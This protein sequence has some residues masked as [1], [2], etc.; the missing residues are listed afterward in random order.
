MMDYELDQTR[1]WQNKQWD[2]FPPL[3]RE[4][5]GGLMA[6]GGPWHNELCGLVDRFQAV[7]NAPSI[8][9]KVAAGV[10]FGLVGGRGGGKTQIAACLGRYTIG[11]GHTAKY[12]TAQ[13]LFRRLRESFNNRNLTEQQVID[14]MVTPSV[15]ILDELHDRA[16]TKHEERTLNAVINDR[17]TR[18]R[19]TL[20]ISD[21]TAERFAESIGPSIASRFEEAG[22]IV[23]VTWPS[24]RTTKP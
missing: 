17:Y 19:F 6:S 2:A 24:F 21:E 3:H 11:A 12:T 5:A 10:L 7:T 15:L 8:T 1:H 23:T 4:R 9:A 22:E 14:E 16:E 13:A 20:L 18:G